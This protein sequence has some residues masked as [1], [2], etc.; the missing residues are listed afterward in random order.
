MQSVVS[1]GG[2][3]MSIKRAWFGQ[4]VSCL[5]LLGAGIVFALVLLDQSPEVNLYWREEGGAAS[6]LIP[7]SSFWPLVPLLGGI[8]LIS[9]LF[10]ASKKRGGNGWWFIPLICVIGLLLGTIVLGGITLLSTPDLVVYQHV[11]FR[12]RTYYVIDSRSWLQ[13]DYWVEECDEV[14]MICHRLTEE[15]FGGEAYQIQVN[16]QTQTLT[17]MLKGKALFTDQPGVSPSW[18]PY[19]LP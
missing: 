5:S 6:G 13:E 11:S 16:A 1:Q 19:G 15:Y 9:W 17:I 2:F 4:L 18:P 10:R 7:A 14:G 3:F 8:A 12:D